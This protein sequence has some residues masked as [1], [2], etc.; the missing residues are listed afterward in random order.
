MAANVTA[1]MLAGAVVSTASVGLGLPVKWILAANLTIN[2]AIFAMVLDHRGR[3]STVETKIH[4]T[5]NDTD[6]DSEVQA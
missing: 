6:D 3:I 2:L 4:M 1:K 5:R